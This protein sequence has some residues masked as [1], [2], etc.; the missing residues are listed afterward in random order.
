MV[1]GESVSAELE[2]TKQEI[3]RCLYN[4]SFEDATEIFND[5]D[6]PYFLG[7]DGQAIIF[8]GFFGW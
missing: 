7:P 2:D 4:G 1:E 5:L 6:Y 3:I 8:R